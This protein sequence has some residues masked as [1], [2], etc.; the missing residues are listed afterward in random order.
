M[1]LE[2]KEKWLHILTC[3][4]HCRYLNIHLTLPFSAIQ[5]TCPSAHWT[6][7]LE[8]STKPF[9][10]GFWIWF[11]CVQMNASRVFCVWSLEKPFLQPCVIQVSGCVLWFCIPRSKFKLL[12]NVLRVRTVYETLWKAYGKLSRRFFVACKLFL[13]RVTVKR[14]E[15][16]DLPLMVYWL[17]WTWL[18]LGMGWKV[19]IVPKG[20]Q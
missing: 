6:W 12:L 4:I 10:L 15:R 7:S 13:P 11:V 5:W 18:V 19:T 14:V 9:P 16:T 20:W 3:R 17:T 1:R 2:R 8:H